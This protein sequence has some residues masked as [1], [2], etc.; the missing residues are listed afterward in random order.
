[1]WMDGR[2]KSRQAG[3]WIG[4]NRK[5]TRTGEIKIKHKKLKSQLTQQFTSPYNSYNLQNVKYFLG[6]YCIFSGSR[7]V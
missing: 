1:M 2:M 7:T 5:E 6:I 4:V 3:G